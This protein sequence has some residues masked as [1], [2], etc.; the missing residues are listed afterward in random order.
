MG[1]SEILIRF[2][3]SRI[4]LKSQ[5]FPLSGNVEQI[6]ILSLDRDYFHAFFEDMRLYHWFDYMNVPCECGV[7]RN[8][9]LR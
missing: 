4:L 3:Q 2:Y 5:M 6:A 1:T 8:F 9:I 7:A